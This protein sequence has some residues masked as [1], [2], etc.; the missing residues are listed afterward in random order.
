M[1][2]TQNTKPTR[3]HGFA[4]GEV[5]EGREGHMHLGGGCDRAELSTA[6]EGQNVVAA[7]LTLHFYQ[8]SAN[9]DA[10]VPNDLELDLLSELAGENVAPIGARYASLDE[11]L[12]YMPILDE[13]DKVI[14]QNSNGTP[15]HTLSV[16]YRFSVDDHRI[17]RD[18]VPAFCRNNRWREVTLATKPE[19]DTMA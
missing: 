2:D 15:V 14:D 7:G 16:T 5:L 13:D 8:A 6:F 10:T 1:A 12:D 4:Y 17:L 3:L 18:T 9:T 19:A 11:S